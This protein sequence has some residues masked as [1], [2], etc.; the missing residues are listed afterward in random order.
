[1]QRRMLLN[2]CLILTVLSVLTACRGGAALVAS[3]PDDHIP[4]RGNTPLVYKGEL[5]AQGP[6]SADWFRVDV[7]GRAIYVYGEAVKPSVQ[8]VFLL[9]H[10]ELRPGEVILDLGTGSGIQSLF[11]AWSGRAGRIV[12]TDIGEDAIKSVRFNV[13]HYGLG[14]LI[15]VREGDLFAPLNKGER[16]SLIINNIDYPASPEEDDH[17]LWKVHERFF[18]EVGARMMP[19]GRIIYQSGHFENIDRIRHMAETNGLVILDMIMQRN[20]FF[21]KDL[22]IYLIEKNPYPQRIK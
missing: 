7:N 2:L 5:S 14:E 20:M 19:G 6:L 16:F 13:Q 10:T 4:V 18:A 8:S 15:E 21:E 9:E 22:I 1:M 3:G 11:A 12:A 17:P